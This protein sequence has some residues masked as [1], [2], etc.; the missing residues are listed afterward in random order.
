MFDSITVTMMLVVN[1]ISA[2]VHIYSISY[3]AKDPHFIRFMAYLSLFTFFMLVLVS[4]DNFIQL[5]LG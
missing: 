1:T 5:F 3:M 2:L 4:A